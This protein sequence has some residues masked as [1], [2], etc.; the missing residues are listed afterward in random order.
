LSFNSNITKNTADAIKKLK[1]LLPM[2]YN[3]NESN[4]NNISDEYLIAFFI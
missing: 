2:T 4:K 1:L 3:A